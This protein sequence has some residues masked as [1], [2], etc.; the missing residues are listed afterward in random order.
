[1]RGH[2]GQK[3]VAVLQP[4]AALLALLLALSITALPYLTLLIRLP[5]TRSEMRV[6]CWFPGYLLAGTAWHLASNAAS[7]DILQTP[8]FSVASQSF[9]VVLYTMFFYLSLA[10]VLKLSKR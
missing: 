1:M 8:A 6:L 2:K 10:V 7:Q 4:K 3:G 5:F 9:N